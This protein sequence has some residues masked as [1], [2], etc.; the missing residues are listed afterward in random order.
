MFLCQ[1]ARKTQ[2]QCYASRKLLI[3]DWIE[4]VWPSMLYIIA[5][6]KTGCLHL[7]SI[8]WSVYLFCKCSEEEPVTFDGSLWRTVLCKRHVP[9]WSKIFIK[10][11]TWTI[12][13]S[14][15]FNADN[16]HDSSWTYYDGRLWFWTH[17]WVSPTACS[18]GNKT[19]WKARLWWKWSFTTKT[20]FPWPHHHQD[21]HHQDHHQQDQHHLQDSWGLPGLCSC[22]CTASLHHLL[23]P[24][25][26]FSYFFSSSIQFTFSTICCN[27][28]VFLSL[29]SIH[30]HYLHLLDFLIDIFHCLN[31]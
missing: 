20:T 3:Y 25:W 5:K 1:Q 16:D 31:L 22:N 17:L 2:N 15:Q 10:T 9:N 12:E 14:W 11:I 30:F 27:L 28:F 24:V 4:N 21:H 29:S 6:G 26:F 13:N 18:T 7:V 19:L 23:Q 8:L